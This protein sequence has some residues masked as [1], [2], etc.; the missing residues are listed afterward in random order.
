MAN[1]V[2]AAPV[3][4]DLTPVVQFEEVVER[5]MTGSA[6]SVATTC[7]ANGISIKAELTS[8]DKGSTTVKNGG[9]PSK[10]DL[11]RADQF[12]TGNRKFNPK[13]YFNSF[14]D[15]EK[16]ALDEDPLWK[17]TKKQLAAKQE[18]IEDPLGV[19]LSVNYVSGE[20]SARVVIGETALIVTSGEVDIGSSLTQKS[21]STKAAASIAKPGKTST[22]VALGVNLG[23]ATT[24]SR[25]LVESN[26]R[27]T[28]GQGVK[29]QSKVNYD[30]PKTDK[31]N[32]V[33]T[34]GE[35]L[36]KLVNEVFNDLVIDNK[37]KDGLWNYVKGKAKGEIMGWAS[38]NVSASISAE[39]QINFALSGALSLITIDNTNEALVEDGAQI[40][41]ESGKL[42]PTGVFPVTISAE[43]EIVQFAAAGSP[44]VK[45][46]FPTADA[47]L[48]KL[49]K[50]LGFTVGGI[51]LGNTTRAIVGG[52]YAASGETPRV[53]TGPTRIAV[54]NNRTSDD[55]EPTVIDV[56]LNVRAT[57]RAMV[58]Q[59][60]FS[61]STDSR[62]SLNGSGAIIDAESRPQRV[63]AAIQPHTTHGLV[64]EAVAGT[65]GDVRVAADDS[66]T[67]VPI[68]GNYDDQ[69][70]QS[71]VS[72]G[73]STG[74]ALMK[75]DVAARLG[76]SLTATAPGAISLTGAGEV[77]LEANGAGLVASNAIAGSERS[78]SNAFADEAL[79]GM[80][81]LEYLDD[82]GVTV[83]R[84][85]VGAS[86]AVAYT[87]VDDTITAT[88]HHNGTMTA[89]EEAPLSVNATN[90]SVVLA[91]T[92]GIIKRNVSGEE[93]TSA[94][95]S[96]AVS[97]INAASTVEASIRQATVHGFS[98]DVAARNARSIGTVAA[99][100]AGGSV[101]GAG[102][103]TVN[104]AGSVAVASLTT[105][106]IATLDRVTGTSLAGARVIA[107]TDDLVWNI[108]GSFVSNF[109]SILMRTGGSDPESLTTG[110]DN[111]R[112]LAVG[113]S[114]TVVNATANTKA[115]VTASDLDFNQ[116]D[117]DVKA[118]ESSTMIT[119]SGG[120]SFV[121]TGGTATAVYSNGNSAGSSISGFVTVVT[122]DPTVEA[123]ITDSTV[124]MSEA[125]GDVS[126]L[127]TTTMLLVTASGG[128]VLNRDGNGTLSTSIGAA[129]TVVNSTARG[130]A[131]ISRS[132]VTVPKGKVRVRSVYG[133]PDDSE[134]EY[135]DPIFSQLNM[136]EAGTGAVWSFA[137]AAVASDS[138][139]SVAASVN[140]T[141][142]DV[143]QTATIA[144]D[145]TVTAVAGS[146]EV[147]ATDEAMIRTVA[148][149]IA[150]TAFTSDRS[151]LS[152]GAAVLVTSLG[153]ETKATIDS[154]SVS[155][156]IDLSA[157]PEID[158]SGR[159]VITAAANADLLT[160]AA[161][162]VMSGN[163][164]L[165]TGL[166]FNDLT[167]RK[168]TAAIT[169]TRSNQPF[170]PSVVSAGKGVTVTA[171]DNTSLTAVAG[172]VAIPASTQGM[173]AA[174][175][176]GVVNH[177]GVDVTAEISEGSSVTSVG[178][179]VRV[180]AIE[181]ST[182]NAW[183]V[184]VSG[185]LSKS[186]TGGMRVPTITFV[187]AGSFA[188]NTVV[189]T[190]TAAVRGGASVTANN[191]TVN[192]ED[193]STINAVA[194][195]LAASY[196][197]DLISV[198]VGISVAR[199]EIGTQIDRG[200]VTATID[201]ASVMLTGDA[202]VTATA[203]P[204]ITSWTIAGT[205]QVAMSDGIAVGLSGAGAGNTNTVAIDTL[206]TITGSANVTTDAGTMVTATDTSK[207]N[208]NAGGAGLGIVLSQSAAVGV[209]VGAAKSDVEVTNTVRA[210]IETGSVAAGGD[211]SLT[212][213]S[214][215]QIEALAFGV[216]INVAKAN[217]G[218]AVSAAGSGASSTV[219]LGTATTA[220]IVS[221]TVTAG[222]G[223]NG[224]VQIAAID[225]PTIETRA[226]AGSLAAAIGTVAGVGL[227]AGV[228]LA[229]NT[230]GNTVTA[231]IGTNGQPTPTVTAHG[232][233]SVDVSAHSAADVKALSVAVAVSAAISKTV[234][235]S[236]GVAV[237]S[238]QSKTAILNEINAEIITG[239]VS[240]ADVN[241]RARNAH[242]SE[243]KVGVGAGVL[244]FIGAS[245]GVSEAT[246][247]IDDVVT[248]RI[249]AAT[250]TAETGDITV[251][252]ESANT[253]DTRSVATS[254]AIAIGGGGT[255]GTAESKETSA[256]KAEILGNAVLTATSGGVNV[257]VG[258]VQ[259]SD[260][261][262]EFGRVAAQS[263]GGSGGL[264]TVGRVLATA[265]H[266]QIRFATVGDG[267]NFANVD[268]LNVNA[269]SKPTVKAH[270]FAVDVGGI[271]SQKNQS[272]A[273]VGGR[274]RSAIGTNTELAGTVLISATGDTTFD[275]HQG[276]GLGGLIGGGNN[277]AKATSKM[278][279]EADL[280]DGVLAA[281]GKTLDRVSINASHADT[282]TVAAT[283]GLGA[284][285]GE[286][287]VTAAM[288][289]ITTTTA[290][291]GKV[292][293][294]DGLTPLTL[295]TL[296][297]TATRNHGYS[298]T[299]T[300]NYGAGIGGGVPMTS[301][302]TTDGTATADA[303]AVVAAGAK[304]AANGTVNL[305]SSHMI[306][307][308]TTGHSARVTGGGVVAISG[309]GDTAGT[310]ITLDAGSRVVI[311]DSATISSGTST[312]SPGGISILPSS[313]IS[314]EDTVGS[315]SGGALSF[316]KLVS[317][318]T[319]SV[320]T[321]VEAGAGVTLAT[322][323][324]LDI[325]TA[326]K[327]TTTTKVV[328]SS[329]GA[330]ARVNFDATADLTVNQH[331]SF[332]ANALLT[333][334]GAT[335]ITGGQ[336]PAALAPQ[337]IMVNTIVDGK[338]TGAIT[339]I[340]VVADS[341]LT[342]STAVT[343]GENASVHSGGDLRIAAETDS[344]I[345]K[346]DG[347]VDY[348]NPQALVNGFLNWFGA[349]IESRQ[350]ST[351][352]P[353]TTTTSRVDLGAGGSFV[354]GSQSDVVLTIPAGFVE[355]SLSGSPAVNL[356]LP[357]TATIDDSFDPHAFINVGFSDD[358]ATI[359]KSQVPADGKAL[360]IS[361][362][363]AAGGSIVI[364]GDTLTGS[365]ALVAN[366]AQITVTNES[367]NHLV[368]DTIVIPNNSSGTIVI[369]DQAGNTTATPSGWSRTEDTA[370]T[371]IT[372]E[373]KAGPISASGQGPAVFLTEKVAN[374]GGAV[375]ITN[376]SGSL[377]VLDTVSTAD[378]NVDV[379]GVAVFSVKGASHAGGPPP[380]QVT[381][382]S[383][384][385]PEALALWQNN[386]SPGDGFT[387]TFAATLSPTTSTAINARQVA[388]VADTINVNG[389]M[390]VGATPTP[391]QSLVVPAVLQAELE[392][393]QKR[394]PR[395]P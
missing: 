164:A 278:S 145:S 114:V 214:R 389:D 372:I 139:L 337:G 318:L 376:A 203:K 140:V 23:F 122:V 201:N 16:K 238:A 180:E 303:R 355:G 272:A 263:D 279:V 363:A 276:G 329:G 11:N 320:T 185:V 113:A 173:V 3:T 63:E 35:K 322:R 112:S 209:T 229:E 305:R 155:A 226:G 2:A 257:V 170:D 31:Y 68:A 286:A 28:G 252:A 132:R 141:N 224:S 346:S 146:V 220:E 235:G 227:A 328:G 233:G 366:D 189:N 330:I 14:L 134:W 142:L 200:T 319:G 157:D 13:A 171:Q 111:G 37:A 317:R 358:A 107:E 186:S 375:T 274:T 190:S 287:Q 156:G 267:I 73:V 255:S 326:A 119:A 86:G 266:A 194:G 331:V 311:G 167:D 53:P 206:A 298:T 160:I 344:P 354:A 109:S 312:D 394:L 168:V 304:I 120:G 179:E 178:G 309:Y 245:I 296:D 208:S 128:F 356:G 285:I 268:T 22:A 351:E 175:A 54:G 392:D 261:T 55:E 302:S 127:A 10:A 352:Q 291:I 84:I 187:G 12:L 181:N 135:F 234:K 223:G 342:N 365:A 26:A 121:S 30:G 270:S 254:L 41:Q 370:G 242:T 50:G 115:I 123:L 361:P 110:T 104:F 105:N 1:A 126:V 158:T 345:V 347:V 260:G 388:I 380:E 118:T 19:S 221:A 40:N 96:G 159:V 215:Q 299:A 166:V 52:S 232:T 251:K 58:F 211:I 393:Y 100:G 79:E 72:V 144:E 275:V 249:G 97:F 210:A 207:V 367:S 163:N 81:L 161:A 228:V 82:G 374:T 169:G 174:G 300:T 292:G 75:R 382:G 362:L 51:A 353:Q 91:N 237:A 191:L 182:M 59:A 204:T 67:L 62:Y 47:T 324:K 131:K 315:W 106:T 43:S 93:K 102:S 277:E 369:Q 256:V 391:D 17:Q 271:S 348:W 247:L 313:N 5:T 385:P 293:S 154:S 33:Q 129:V 288:T 269:T 38:H 148:G 34:D 308:T 147:T 76:D 280:G 339:N 377:G 195:A 192:A 246:A 239:V 46:E 49:N 350:R 281:P 325:G 36:E 18:G 236:V 383:L 217:G 243:N 124:T 306:T 193:S 70:D 384:T 364:S 143:F 188:V 295:G 151:T 87:K 24:I 133:N 231:R 338:V 15:K 265:E 177:V 116:G 395:W 250:V 323:G 386:G 248:A 294:A 218:L 21:F 64:I 25:T 85:G 282:S 219:T 138:A 241:V 284:I 244:A 56:G 77:N 39:D 368:F 9:D 213:E 32:L 20:R 316:G 8:T 258:G 117:F 202:V 108:A 57:G 332:G 83:D 390:I 283:N 60:A 373:Q 289:D 205:G 336:D 162:G 150:T 371:S 387:R 89:T 101:G 357:V 136:P 297:V 359:L 78:A 216:G 222:I 310:T 379:H 341:R 327:A 88:V 27:I 253:I 273:T 321:N 29:I 230:L 92:G 378:L 259:G 264:L 137:V 98:I 176:A 335:R 99:S 240:A 165:S 42:D 7:T 199:N 130:T 4:M 262:L 343:F 153:G 360:R 198:A 381:V 71:V 149:S 61:G 196:T 95:L 6:H 74:I 152:A 333:S 44:S 183:A 80:A 212:A 172:Q 125:G 69:K 184:G 225:T 90:T 45:K 66:T 103:T 334:N 340:G 94:G 307:R 290:T 301:F 349:G 197:D 48:K 65:A 314:I